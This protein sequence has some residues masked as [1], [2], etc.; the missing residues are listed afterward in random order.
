M[1]QK[2]Q[3]LN[4]PTRMIHL[5]HNFLSN[6]QQVVR[7]GSTTSSALTIKTGAPQGC[8]LS[9]FLYTLYTNDNIS[10]SP[11]IKYFKYSDDT[12]I[13]ALL[14]DDNST[15]DLDYN[16]TV[17]HFTKWCAYNHLHFN[18]KKTKELIFN[19]TSPQ[20]P[21]VID[22]QTVE[23]VDS[24][25]YL[26]VTI[27]SALTFDQHHR[28]SKEKLTTINNPETERTLAPPLLLRLYQSIIQPVMLYCSTCFFNLLTVKNRTKLI[29]VTNTAAKIVGLPAPSL[30][31]LNNRAIGRFAFSIEQDHAHPLPEHLT[32]LPSGRRYRALRCKKAQLG[33]SLIPLVITFLN[34]RGR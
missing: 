14:K 27:D 13:L 10:L 7:L 5:L 11:H 15:M 28:H 32:P 30:T 24:F 8:V 19:S 1:I 34:N 2:L 33:R 16:N 6:S 12:A 3:H 9:P 21:I 31:E 22:N 23:I 4:I 26:G 18:V 17:T 29:K 25:K 20:Q